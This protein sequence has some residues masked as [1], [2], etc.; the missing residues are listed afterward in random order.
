M[1]SVALKTRL[2]GLGYTLYP[3]QMNFLGVPAELSQ[4]FSVR[5]I[6]PVS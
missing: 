6:A 1:V 3:V 5:G 2:Q 4:R